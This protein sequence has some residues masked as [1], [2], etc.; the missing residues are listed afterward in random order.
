MGISINTSLSIPSVSN[1]FFKFS[2]NFLTTSIL[3]KI[4]LKYAL[5]GIRTP[6]PRFRRPMLYPVEPRV[7]R[8]CVPGRNRT[9]NLW[10]RKPML[11][12][13]ELQVHISLIL[14]QSPYISLFLS[15]KNLYIS[16]LKPLN[17]LYV[18]V[19]KLILLPIATYCHF[20]FYDI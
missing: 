13:V 4:Y 10:F 17:C 6:N 5:G 12:P 1:D 14:S 15:R 2:S 7:Q 18:W 16:T 20:W 11:Y 9:D 19:S 8:S 3:L